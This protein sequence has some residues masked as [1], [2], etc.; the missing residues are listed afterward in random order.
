MDFLRRSFRSVPLIRPFGPPS[1]RRKEEQAAPPVIPF[2]PCGRRCHEVTD[3]G[4]SSETSTPHPSR[5]FEQA[6]SPQGEK[7]ARVFVATASIEAG[8][9][10]L[11]PRTG[12]DKARADSP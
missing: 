7:E 1:P 2:S 12:E 3:E 5:R 6:P 10:M 4:C 11:P 9:K 8:R